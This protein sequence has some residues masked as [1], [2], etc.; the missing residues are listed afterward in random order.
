[1]QLGAA[2]EQHAIGREQ[3]DGQRLSSLSDDARAVMLERHRVLRLAQPVHGE[4]L[5]DDGVRWPPCG[6]P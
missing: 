2:C 3:R 5:A 1:M 4:M 6:Q